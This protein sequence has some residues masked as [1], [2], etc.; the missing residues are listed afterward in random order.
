[1]S[2]LSGA[3][4]AATV[5]VALL[6]AR[7][8][9]RE[10]SFTRQASM[11]HSFHE[12]YHN[13]EMRLFRR[14]LLAGEFGLPEEFDPD[15]LEVDDL[16][17]FNMLLDQL[18]F[19]G[20]M[21]EQELLRSDLFISAFH[22]TPPFVWEYVKPWTYQRRAESPPPIKY[23]HLE[24]LADVY[25]KYFLENYGTR[26]PARTET[27]EWSQRIESSD[28]SKTRLTDAAQSD[29]VPDGIA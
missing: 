1:M 25:D 22:R 14:R 24:R 29:A 16:T 5:I 6:Y 12:M 7:G 2:A 10:A 13:P 23:T 9:V 28:L 18:E 4:A 27:P 19:M 21:I 15:R 8:Q 20:V 3:L 11:I 26:H 17:R